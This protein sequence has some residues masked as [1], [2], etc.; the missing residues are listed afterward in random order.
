MNTLRLIAGLEFFKGII[1]LVVSIFLFHLSGEGDEL[2]IPNLFRHIH[3]FSAGPFFYKN[4]ID[5]NFNKEGFLLVWAT[6]YSS[7]RFLEAYGLWKLKNWGFLIGIVSVSIYLPFEVFEILKDVTI[8]K[9]IITL[10]NLVI[11][12]YLIKKRRR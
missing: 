9:I 6:I 4:L 5:A 3:A 12:I 7:L 10:I 11:L 1:V 8:I 2:K